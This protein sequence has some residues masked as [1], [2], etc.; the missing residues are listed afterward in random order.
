MVYNDA[1]NSI[2]TERI[3]DVEESL[4]KEFMESQLKRLFKQAGVQTQ[5]DLDRKLRALGS[6]LEREKRW[7]MEQALAQ[8]WIGQQVKTDEEIT[9]LEMLEWYQGHLHVFD[10]PARARWEELMVRIDKRPSKAE[11]YA[12]LARMGTQVLAGAPLAAV[13]KAQSDGPTAFNGG[14]RDWTTKGSLVAENLDRALFGLPIG[15]LSPILESNSGFHIIRVVERQDATRTPFAD[16][17]NDV[18]KMIRQERSNK[19]YKEYM[20]KMAR[21]YPAWTIFDDDAS[22]PESLSRRPETGPY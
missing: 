3:A 9:H 12:A 13:A 10:K 7:F 22:R 5:E 18:K 8:Q 21:L 14:L 2:P 6:S 11:A 1:R 20:A 16:A 19:K 15:Q 4:S 17:Q